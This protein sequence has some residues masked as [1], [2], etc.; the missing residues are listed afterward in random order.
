MGINCIIIDTFIAYSQRFTRGKA[1]L[2]NASDIF[3]CIAFLASAS[4]FS[5]VRLH[6]TLA[7]GVVGELRI[8]GACCALME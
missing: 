3:K 6:S 4:T 5:S 1:T 2:L 7:L 8:D